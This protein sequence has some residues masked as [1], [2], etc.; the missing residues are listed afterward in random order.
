M[1]TR[2]KG[3]KTLFGN[4]TNIILVEVVVG[5]VARSDIIF[6]EALLE[7]TMNVAILGEDH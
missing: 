6:H 2:G 3:F 1:S 7:I 4:T 5:V